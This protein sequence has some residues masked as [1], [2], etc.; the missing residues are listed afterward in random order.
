MAKA[1]ELLKEKKLNQKKVSGVVTDIQKYSSISSAEKPAFDSEKSQ[2]EEVS[3][4]IQS[5]LDLLDRRAKIKVIIDQTNINT[6]IRIPKGLVFGEHEISVAEALM[7]KLN[8]KE[9]QSI[10]MA[11]NRTAA[12]MKISRSVLNSDGTKAS[13]IQLYDENYKNNALKD[14]QMKLDHIDSHLEMLNATTEVSEN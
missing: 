3:K 11:L 5:G 13:A 8:Y 1:I 9:Y 12:D 6:K 14:L 4:L 7:F 10:F 2:R